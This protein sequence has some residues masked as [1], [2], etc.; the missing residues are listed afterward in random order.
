MRIP[1]AL[2]LLAILSCHRA[3]SP[4][5]GDAK[6]AVRI[7]QFY[8]SP[9]VIAPGDTTNLCFGVEFADSVEIDPP[10]ERLWPTLSR[11][12]AVQPKTTTSYTLRARGASGVA[13]QV[14]NVVVDAR[15]RAEI[16]PAEPLI[17]FF[18]ASA[19]TIGR[20]QPVTLCYGVKNA[21]SVRL[22]PNVMKI[23]PSERH[24]FRLILDTTSRF[25]LVAR[26]AAGRTDRETVVVQVK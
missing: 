10:V 24:C 12:I 4:S 7:T 17:Q 22:E 13:T 8:P 2:A 25:T 18:A 9:P 19:D 16:P 11:C 20:G 3:P 6:P 14:V 15:A 23:E 5:A 1:A 21:T 26:D